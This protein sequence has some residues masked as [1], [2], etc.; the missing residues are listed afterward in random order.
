LNDSES[1]A[2]G[3]RQ[4]GD[5]TSDVPDFP[6]E[7]SSVVIP[8]G[9][10]ILDR[11][12]LSDLCPRGTDVAD[13]TFEPESQ[14]RRIEEKCFAFRSMKPIYIPR[15]VEV[16]GK[17][18]FCGS[19]TDTNCSR[20]EA[21]RFETESQLLQIPDWCFYRSSIGLIIVPESVQ[22][23]CTG[24]F[25]FAS[26]TTLIF[27]DNSR[28][29]RIEQESFAHC[30]LSSISIP[31]SV[32]VLGKSCFKCAGGQ[33]G[34]PI[35]FT[36]DSESRLER[37]GEYCFSGCSLESI[38]IP[39]SVEILEKSCFEWAHVKIFTVENESRLVRI[40]E[41][42]FWNCVIK[43][44]RIPRC[45]EFVGPSCFESVPGETRP[46]LRNPAF[47]IP[48]DSFT[49]DPG[50]SL[51]RISDLCFRSCRLESLCVPCSVEILG[52]SCFSHAKIDVL[53]FESESNLRTIQESCFDHCILKSIRLP[54]LVEAL[55]ALC[56]N[57]AIVE[58]VAF[59]KESLLKLIG[60]SC[61]FCCQI[62]SISI[63]PSVEVL[64]KDCFRFP[65]AALKEDLRTV[66]GSVTCFTFEEPSGLRQIAES[67][68]SGASIKKICIPRLIEVLPISCF[69]QA[70]IETL[71]FES[72]TVLRKIDES[73]FQYCSIRTLV[74]PRSVEFLGR[75]CFAGSR[76]QILGPRPHGY[77]F[78][79]IETVTFEEGSILG[80]LAE[81]CFQFSTV[82]LVRIPRFVEV[83]PKK[84]FEQ[85]YHNNLVRT[86]GKDAVAYSTVTK[87][88][89]STQFSGRKEATSP[90]APNVELSP[91]D[92]A[93][94][95]ALAE[96]PFPFSSVRELSRR[97]C[98]PR[99]TVHPH[100]H[101]TQLLRFT[102]RHL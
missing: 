51:R 98:L 100:W 39:R 84:C 35:E 83:L 6:P 60:E 45:V 36:F 41:S 44:I 62:Q 34:S 52:K 72:S 94:F 90:E 49:F 13:L 65:P 58:I 47:G 23:L 37:I 22:V 93:I 66:R 5:G 12:T 70:R 67:C 24:C 3:S 88:A 48:M 55:P 86:H 101:L 75:F 61:F 99:S 53:S 79:R 26:I 92:E 63:P 27:Q 20:I 28:L 42:C 80:T 56:F 97:I 54:R 8:R 11:A 102:V 38:C 74:I 68:F 16:L 18:C 59:E 77:D 25:E 57:Y 31:R 96:F 1:T 14:L 43:L 73:C 29:Q 33:P 32:E 7:V 4:T 78:A 91:V 21:I 69:K 2:P 95:T 9:I 82:K 19:K 71:A 81:S 50:S 85:A 76:D 30:K 10:E 64:D 15:S 87:Y 17:W 40:E 89:R 46:E